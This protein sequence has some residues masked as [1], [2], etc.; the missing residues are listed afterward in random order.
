M[1]GEQDGAGHVGGRGAHKLDC[2]AATAATDV[3]NPSQHSSHSDIAHQPPTNSKVSLLS[4]G[5]AHS[6]EAQAYVS[7]AVALPTRAPR[8]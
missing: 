5:P 3:A 6:G 1:P 4:T 7:E 8:S 2:R